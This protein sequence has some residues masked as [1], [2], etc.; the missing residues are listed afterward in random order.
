MFGKE[1]FTTLVLRTENAETAAELKRF[2]SEDYK[3]AAVNAQVEIE[4]YRGLAETTDQFTY[5]IGFIAVVMSIGGVFGVMNT[6]FAAISQRTGDIGVLR[7]LGLR[8]VAHPGIVPVGIVGDRLDRRAVGL[9]S[10]LVDRR[11]DRD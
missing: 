8:P 1:T 11:L 7:L 6:M 4:Y 5:A 3:K 10:R 9:R 2:L